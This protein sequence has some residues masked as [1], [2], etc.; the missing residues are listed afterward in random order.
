MSGAERHE[1]ISRIMR[2]CLEAPP[3]ERDALLHREAADDPSILREVRNLLD[4]DAADD[5]DVFSDDAI[6]GGRLALHQFIDDATSA[7][8]DA[9][10]IPESIASYRVIRKIGEGGMGVVFEAEQDNPRRRVALKVIRAHT[11]S[12]QLVK[13]FQ[14]EAYVLGRLTHPGIAHVYESG[15]ATIGA[16]RLPYLAMELI[17]GPPLDEFVQRREMSVRQRLELIA[18]TA[19]AIHHAHEKGVIHRDLKPS[20]ILV[21]AEVVSAHDASP[22]GGDFTERPGDTAG[23]G[24]PRI[25][26]FGVARAA[27]ADAHLATL[28]THAGILVG[29]ITYMSPEQVAGDPDALDRRC[30]IY[31]LGA[32]LHELLTGKPPLDVR[33]RTIAEAAQIIRDEEP[34]R[35]GSV[36]TLFRGD[37]ETIV[38][39]ALDKDPNRR[40]QTAADMAADIRRYLCHRPIQARPASAWYRACKFTRRNRVLVGGLAATLLVLVIGLMSTTWLALREADAH[41]EADRSLYRAGLAVADAALRDGDVVTARQH[42]EAAPPELRGWEWSHYTARL[43]Q[44]SASA[45][46][47]EH[48]RTMYGPDMRGLAQIWFSDSDK[49]LHVGFFC[50]RDQQLEVGAWDAST[51]DRRHIWFVPNGRVFAPV[52]RTSIMILQPDNRGRL[53][54]SDDGEPGVETT[55]SLEP[56]RR[57]SLKSAIPESLSETSLSSQVR[58]GLTDASTV[59]FSPDGRF[60]CVATFVRD[61]SVYSLDG[62]QPPIKLE[63]HDEGIGDA[64]FSSDGRHLF[65]AG[66]DRRLACFDLRDNGRRVWERRD[67]HQDAIL[68]AALSPDDRTLVT[69]GQDRLLRIWDAR[70]GAPIGRLAGH[71]DP[72]LAV[73]FDSDGQRIASFSSEV[74][75]TW[76]LE[77]IDDLSV[78][79]GHT[80]YVQS[81]AIS[82]DGALLASCGERLC[83]WDVQTGFQIY[84]G[85]ARGDVQSATV[86]FSADGRHLLVYQ[87]YIRNEDRLNDAYLLD[88]CTGT[89]EPIPGLEA[90]PA[91]AAF[92]A[93]GRFVFVEQPDGVCRLL[94]SKTHQRRIT[95]ENAREV[96][97][98]GS[99]RRLAALSDDRIQIRRTSDGAILR[100]WREPLASRLFVSHDESVLAVALSPGPIDLFD[101]ESGRK[102]G[103]LAGHASRVTCFG[104]LP[105]C[106]R[107][108]TGSDDRTIR[109]WDL[110]RFE[111]VCV[112]RGHTDRIWALAVSRDEKSI[113]S[114]SGDYTIRRWDTQPVSALIKARET[115]RAVTELLAPKVNA[116]LTRHDNDTIAVA[117]QIAADPALSERE[118]RV[119]HQIL[120][121]AQSNSNPDHAAQHRSEIA[122]PD[123]ARPGD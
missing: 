54:R 119:A 12:P 82:P 50:V 30:D 16:D 97:V 100:S 17:D 105:D 102:L 94:D 63:P 27:D 108:I 110:D 122:P 8:V 77:A 96:S 86:S 51:L 80:W 14:R 87:R 89:T 109:L 6:R 39:K 43:D 46:F 83:V 73:G 23:V 123:R 10:P 62:A 85:P 111:E 88:T 37:V 91:G 71:R 53:Y 24:Q 117:K 44:S 40:Y 21:V 120:L 35:L 3:G 29:T 19:E 81:V 34:S 107:L 48:M 115:Y 101:M 36:N 121:H 28:A 31:A 5:A 113:F 13:R 61:V 98:E 64:V 41:R 33:R 75:K 55:L 22:G 79:R 95:L 7:P 9:A 20:N 72:I 15:F 58:T 32:I 67:A 76:R 106:H 68:A 114:A 1:R 78:M 49:L 2:A 56:S 57:M 11:A 60:V 74:V 92:V 65:T 25:V 118:R 104:E 90:P 93:H 69:G 52:G 18:L 99:G 103:T 38:S 42:L 47:S 4:F 70:T 116:W 112:L 84:S 66:N 45:P 26:D 59:A